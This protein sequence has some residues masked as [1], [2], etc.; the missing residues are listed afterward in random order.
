MGFTRCSL[1]SKLIPLLFT[2]FNNT[3][4]GCLTKKVLKK[5]APKLMSTVFS[6]SL[7]MRM[8]TVFCDFPCPVIK[9]RLL[10]L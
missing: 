5:T 9:N 10:L 4:T 2:L 6:P 8:Q 3:I 1:T 7:K